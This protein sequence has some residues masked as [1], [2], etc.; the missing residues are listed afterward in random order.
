MENTLSTGNHR[1]KALEKAIIHTQR[2]LGSVL[3]SERLAELKAELVIMQN[4]GMSVSAIA[5]ER[6]MKVPFVEK[7][8]GIGQVSYDF[9]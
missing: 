6:N 3:E 8:L 2:N 7:L 9:G 5:R 1:V 4:D